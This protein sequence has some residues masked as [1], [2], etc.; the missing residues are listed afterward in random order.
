VT[1]AIN[2]ADQA[3]SAK[4]LTN[5]ITYAQNAAYA[6]PGE[7]SSLQESGTTLTYTFW[8]N[9][10]L[11]P[12][13]ITVQS[14]GTAPGSCTAATTG[15]V[16][17]FTYNYKWSV[18][19]NGNAA[20]I[21]NNIN[22]ARSQSFTY[23][24]LNRVSTAN[25]QAT[26][27]TYAWG[28]KFGYDA[29][30]NLLSATT[31]QGS[32]TN[33]CVNAA[34]SN[35]LTTTCQGSTSFTYDAAGDMTYDGRN[36]YAFNGEG[37]L[38]SITS[39]ANTTYTYDGDGNR[40]QK[41]TTGTPYRLYWYG[42]GS[43]PLSESDASGNLTA[44]YIFFNGRRAAMLNISTS[45]VSYYVE[46]HLGSSRV[47]TNASGAIQDDS[48]FTPYGGE[49]DYQSSS[50]NHYKFTGK[51]RDPESAS[52][53]GGPDGLDDF[54]ARFYSSN[55]GRFM[56]PDD[57][58]YMVLADPQTFNLYSY[59]ANNPINA[60]DP[61][62]HS[63]YG[64][65]DVPFA[66][67]EGGGG[68]GVWGGCVQCESNMNSSG[69]APQNNSGTANS[70]SNSASVAESESNE[71]PPPPPTTSN[72]VTPDTTGS[73]TGAAALLGAQTCGSGICLS[74]TEV[75]ESQVV[76]N[77]KLNNNTVTGVGAQL[78]IS[79]IGG[80]GKPLSGSATESNAEGGL[81]NPNAVP[82]VQGSIRDWIG[83]FGDASKNPG[84]LQ[85]LKDYVTT[86]PISVT[87]NQTL[88][89]NTANSTYQIKWTRTFSNVDNKGNLNETFNS[90]GMN[91]NSTWTTPVIKLM[92]H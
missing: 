24:E 83:K 26:T 30:A 79:L 23:D 39:A 76:E 78:Q 61:T 20:S 84:T 75:Q 12:C 82:L 53:S 1:F 7:L 50:G 46:D 42:I 5:N 71:P 14:S 57:S 59:V 40:V 49:N 35:R 15:N 60:V 80:D 77:L 32:A 13:R 3:T 19:D 41:A 86:N 44:E 81:Q 73:A 66:L 64:P 62:G 17:D 18:A 29:W 56:S 37:E 38:A 48:D 10:R 6:P 52:S 74:V 22:T 11:Q 16:L 36:Y 21:T 4:D 87:S 91:F 58:K 9:N 45:A 27:G 28:L 34:V 31:T 51:E 68:Y 70:G 90:H 25:T 88:T 33:L 47:I 72:D 8:Y 89:I 69:G 43:D 2:A 92:P 85:D 65:V 63:P 67:P 54:A 55:Y